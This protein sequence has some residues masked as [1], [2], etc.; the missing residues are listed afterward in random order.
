MTI[1][2]QK[3]DCLSE[4][5]VKLQ[6]EDKKGYESSMMN[7]QHIKSEVL[8]L[9]DDVSQLQKDVY[10]LNEK[11]DK[12][13]NNVSEI[14]RILSSRDKLP[15]KITD[16]ESDVADIGVSK[17]SILQD[18]DRNPAYPDQLVKNKVST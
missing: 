1:L 18:T 11:V 17:P 7:V 12:L 6:K 9:K 8:P 14:L 5:H 10:D 4:D 16:S 3:F 15:G 13:N 2:D